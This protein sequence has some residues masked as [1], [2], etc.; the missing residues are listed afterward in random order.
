MSMPLFRSGGPMMD[1]VE[2]AVGSKTGF[3]AVD[4]LE[5]AECIADILFNEPEDNNKIRAAAR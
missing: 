4:A 1:I 2:T 3:L 5:Y